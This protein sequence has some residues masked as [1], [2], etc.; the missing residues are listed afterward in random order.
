MST[1]LNK[2]MIFSWIISLGIPAIIML[3]PVTESYTIEIHKFLACTLWMILA[4][5]LECFPSGVFIPAFLYPV[6]LVYLKVAT[7]VQAYAG[8]TNQV[9]FVIIIAF[10]LALALERN[11]LLNRIAYWCMV[12]AKGSFLKV[13]YAIFVV[14]LICTVITFGNSYVF[15][16]AF[17][18]GLIKGIGLNPGKQSAIL[19]WSA[20]LGTMT[21]RLFVWAPQKG[22]QITAAAAEVV[23]GFELSIFNQ[24]WIELPVILFTL[25]VLWVSPKLFLKKEERSLG[26]SGEMFEEKLQSLGTMSNKEK[27]CALIVVIMIVFILTNP[28]HKVA[29]NYAFLFIIPI[30]FLPGIDAADRKCT[31]LKWDMVFFASSCISVGVVGAALGVHTII[32]GLAM[33]ILSTMSAKMASFGVWL[34]VVALNFILTPTAMYSALPGVLA[35]MALTLGYSP[36]IFIYQLVNASDMVFLS[37]EFIPYLIFASFGMISF[38]EF[39]KLSTFKIL[40]FAVFIWLLL[41]PWWTIIGLL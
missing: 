31:D 12:K 19:T 27:W 41:F 7:P 22:G 26:I 15:L 29:I 5:A 39:L 24:L 6:L 35:Q 30:L 17:V 21:V 28:I 9:L 33:P 13:Y 14:C 1:T 10:A 16:A 40:C 2:K 37:Y 36:E 4:V 20:L 38:N 34:L 18:Y 8:W 3:T 25:F 11:G 23:P 32:S